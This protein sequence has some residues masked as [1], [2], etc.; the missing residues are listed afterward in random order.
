MRRQFKA[1]SEKDTK[2][3]AQALAEEIL[4]TKPGKA[5]LIV[6]LVG[7]LGSGKTTF[8][9]A[10]IRAL[11]IKTRVVSPTFIFSRR[12]KGKLYKYIWHFDL[13]RLRSPREAEAIGLT[14]AVK[15]KESLV[16][17]E[18]ADK[19]KRIIPQATIWIEFKHSCKPNERYLTFN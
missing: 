17:I 10:L 1:K 8:I 9:K 16:L 6:A 14:A 15:S 13:Y 7:E 2:K 18:W 4:R 5:A 11:G 12:F 19:A 3:L